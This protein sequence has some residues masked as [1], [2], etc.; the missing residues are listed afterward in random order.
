MSFLSKRFVWGCLVANWEVANQRGC[1]LIGS[2]WFARLLNGELSLFFKLFVLFLIKYSK[3]YSFFETSVSV[4]AI[5][6]VQRYEGRFKGVGDGLTWAPLPKPSVVSK[7][8]S[9]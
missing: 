1:I 5:F 4:R 3:I 6:N 9:R 8:Q 7:E 2:L